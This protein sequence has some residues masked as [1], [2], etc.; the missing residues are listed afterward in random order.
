MTCFLVN[1]HVSIFY[2]WNKTEE[3]NYI[4]WFKSTVFHRLQC[5][6]TIILW[7]IIF[8]LFKSYEPTWNFLPKLVK[9]P[10]LKW[11]QLIYETANVPG[12]LWQLPCLALTKS[13]LLFVFLLYVQYLFS[14]TYHCLQRWV[15]ARKRLKRFFISLCLVPMEKS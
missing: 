12:P 14:C 15:S 5:W 3:T 7:R 13:V 2:L 9:Y 11:T 10:F 4:L 1:I 6:K 8:I